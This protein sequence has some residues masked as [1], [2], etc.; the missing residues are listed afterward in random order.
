MS[1]VRQLVQEVSEITGVP[2]TEAEVEDAIVEVAHRRPELLMGPYLGGDH[3]DT[4]EQIGQNIEA[5]CQRARLLHER[6]VFA[7]LETPEGVEMLK[8]MVKATQEQQHQLP[9]IQLSGRDYNPKSWD[10]EGVEVIQL[11]KTESILANKDLMESIKK[12]C[13]SMRR[14]GEWLTHKEV[15]GKEE[16]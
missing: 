5:A 9:Q 14:G 2:L 11:D 3:A 15:F 7:N 13:E 1:I 10:V 16:E 8:E 12:G 4:G 6:T